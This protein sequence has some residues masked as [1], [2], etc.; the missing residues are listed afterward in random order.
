[1]RWL[2]I[3]GLCLLVAG[4][5]CAQEVVREGTMD[6]LVIASGG[7]AKPWSVA[8]ATLTS[9]PELVK[10]GSAAL[11]FHVDVDYATGEKAYPIGWPRMTL[12]LGKPWQ[13][14]WSGFD[15]LRM[16]IHTATS[17]EALPRSPLG[18]SLYTPDK[19]R[20]YS[21]TLT[22]L[23]PGEW[24]K[25]EIPLSQIARHENVTGIQFHIAEANYRDHDVLDFTI[26]D[27]CLLRYAQPTLGDF[28]VNPA[29]MFADTGHLAAAFYVLGL[30]PGEEVEAEAALVAEGKALLSTRRRVTRGPQSLALT[31]AG[32]ALPPG[33]YAMRVRLGAA[34]PQ[35][36][37]V[38]VVTSPWAQ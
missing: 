8:E 26:D 37:A 33:E 7:D 13:R 2:V 5:G 29:V 32:S 24:V 35:E 36:R 3:L 6:K 12:T 34:P 11:R 20:G 4:V 30:K 21:R 14:D 25:L 10:T 23:K 17:R 28:T 1:M 38:R 19:N 18:M 15:F 27:I 16:W 31:L 22:E 9:S